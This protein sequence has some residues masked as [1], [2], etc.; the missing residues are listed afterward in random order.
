MGENI[1]NAIPLSFHPCQTKLLKFIQ[2][3]DEYCLLNYLVICQLIYLFFF[4]IGQSF[5]AV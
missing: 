1:Q 2:V 5:T 3:I 4:V